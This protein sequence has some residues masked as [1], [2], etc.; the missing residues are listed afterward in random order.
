MSNP[1]EIRTDYAGQPLGPESVNSDPMTLLTSWFEEAVDTGVPDANAMTLATIGSDGAP[2]AR[3]VLMKGLSTEGVSFF[4]NYSSNKGAELAADGRCSLCFFWQPLSRQ[5]R[6]SGVAERLSAE[7]SEEYFLSRPQLSK[8]GAWASPQSQKIDSREWLQ[9]EFDRYQQRFG[10]A[11]PR[12]EHWGG[13]LVRPNRCE[14]W[15]GRRARL[16]DRV[17][18]ER[19]GNTWEKS[20]L[21][22]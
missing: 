13:Y 18:Y 14:F 16:H 22:P 20:R 12:P 15:Q 19:N 11:V 17:L 5:V 7:A 21:A 4:T 3:V 10:E 8:I 6:V 9:S 2:L 1:A